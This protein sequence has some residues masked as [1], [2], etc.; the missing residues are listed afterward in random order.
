MP[1]T[2][3]LEPDDRPGR[4]VRVSGMTIELHR[5][6]TESGLPGVVVIPEAGDTEVILTLR[7]FLS[8]ARGLRAK[9]ETWPEW[10]QADTP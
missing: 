1:I 4:V 7:E 9:A 10:Q 5:E 3:N 2:L 6:A 8:A